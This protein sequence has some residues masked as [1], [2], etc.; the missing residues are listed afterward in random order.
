MDGEACGMWRRRRIPQASPPF[1]SSCLFSLP[2]LD[3][4]LARRAT[5]AQIS[6]G[7]GRVTNARNPRVMQGFF[8][9]YRAWLINHCNVEAGLPAPF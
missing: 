2:S 9:S 1:R 7:F 4:L 6:E 3:E 5:G 8:E